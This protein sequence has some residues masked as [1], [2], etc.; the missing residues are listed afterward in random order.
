M[1]KRALI[2][3]VYRCNE[4]GYSVS[5]TD[6]RQAWAMKARM[7]R[8]DEFTCR[9][10]DCYN[11]MAVFQRLGFW[12]TLKWVLRDIRHNARGF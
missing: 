8:N 11:G 7:T 2:G 4:C 1:D 10:P 6:V 12:Q 5:I 9:C 3:G